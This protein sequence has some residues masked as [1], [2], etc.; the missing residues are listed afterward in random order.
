MIMKNEKKHLPRLAEQIKRFADQWL[1]VDTGSTDGSVELAKSLGAEVHHFDWIE[2][3]AA[4]RNETHKYVKTDYVLWLDADD[5]IRD[6]EALIEFKKTMMA[7]ADMWLAT[8]NYAISKEGKS[9]CSFT[10]ERVY[11]SNLGFYWKY[12]IHEG[13][14]VD[15]P[16]NAQLVTTWAIDHLRSPEDLETDKGRNLRVFEAQKSKG[17]D[18]RMQY[19][20][21]KELF[22]AGKIKESIKELALASTRKELEPHDRTLCHQYLC[23]GLV[24]EGKYIEAINTAH[25]GLLISPGRAEFFC[26]VGDAYLK[27]EQPANAIP[28]YEAAKACTPMPEKGFAGFIYQHREMYEHYPRLQL[29]RIYVHIGQLEKAVD[30]ADKCYALYKNEEGR[31]VSEEARKVLIRSRQHQFAKPCDDIVFTCLGGLYE[32]D[33]KI[34]K[35]K[36]IGGSETACVEMAK[37]LKKLTNRRVIVFNHPRDVY[38][39]A[40]SGVEYLKLDGIAPYFAVSKPALH[41]AWRH[42]MK[43]TDAKTLVWSHDLVTSGGEI[44]DRYEKYLVLSKFHKSFVKNALMLPDEKIS[45]F[46]NGVE[47]TRFKA[48]NQTRKNPNKIVY[49][50]SPD[51]GLDRA[52]DVVELARVENPDLEL[53]VFYGVDNL[54]KF[55]KIQ[56]AERFEKMMQ[57]P[58]IKYH[59]NVDQK[60]LLEHYREASVWLYPTNFMETFCISALETVLCGVYPL[61]RN[62]GAL[63][64][65]LKDIPSTIVDRDCESM[66]D[67]LYW[68]GRLNHT[69]KEKMWHNITQELHS[70]LLSKFSWEQAAKDWTEEYLK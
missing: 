28:W 14:N 48:L 60:E 62:Y 52:I 3:F 51:R 15:K 30:E 70:E 65:T 6:I 57:K 32:W 55:G 63:P 18:A 59:G 67:K 41:I 69:I 16:F 35:E 53:H 61:V 49:V 46:R 31:L 45:V 23:F 27:L 43:L 37:W 40:D 68:A 9:L 56:E 10:R 39:V 22:E 58:W 66:E 7:T 20:Y 1:I 33:E 47:P 8:Y 29:A 50:S 54:R 24:R 5:S 64:D 25:S 4:A 11:K 42:N 21:G 17:L 12:P 2:D 38:Y 44:T 26:I 36:G 13:L 19:Y 34:Y